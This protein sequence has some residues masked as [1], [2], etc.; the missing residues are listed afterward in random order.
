MVTVDAHG[1]ARPTIAGLLAFGRDPGTFLPQACIEAA[2][3]AGVERD[4][5]QLLDWRRIGGAVGQQVAEAMKF[6]DGAMRRP[7]T[8]DV[9]RLDQPQYDLSA[10]YEA[11]VNAVAHRD[12]SVRGAKTRLYMFADRLELYTPG[13]LPNSMTHDE[14]A[15]RVVT[16][17]QLLVDFLRRIKSPSTGRGY[18]ESRG[19]GVR[20]ILEASEAHAGLR[21][22][23]RE[24]SQ[25]LL[26]TSWAKP[27]PHA[28]N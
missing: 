27:S 28:A 26:L 19:E 17:N 4:S 14:L 21:P 12:Y 9:G 2:A 24:F 18:L 3:Y 20:R 25:E 13:S 23:Y 11:V 22:Q 10:V 15:H 7:A 16:R 5:A 1:A 8:K 6:V